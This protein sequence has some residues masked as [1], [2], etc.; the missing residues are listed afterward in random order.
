MTGASDSFWLPRAGSTLARE[1]DASFNLVYWVAVFFFLLVVGALV[2]FVVRY[3]RKVGAEVPRAPDHNTPIEIVWTA[4]PV[5]IVLVLFAVGFRVYLKSSVAP[6]DAM[7]VSVT[8]ERWMWTFTYPNGTVSVNELRVPRARPVKLILSSRDV[9]HSFFV[10]EM[11][12][13]KDAVPN[14]YTTLWFEA[15]EAGES[16]IQCTEYCGA[17]HS[18]MLG[19]LIVQED[20]DFDNWLESGGGDNKLP[21]AELG[22]RL[23]AKMACNTC[24][25]TDGLPKTGPTFKGIYGT[26]VELADG[27]SALVDE[28]YIRES[29]TSPAAKVVRGFQPVMPVFKGLLTQKQIDGLVAFIKEQK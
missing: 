27:T 8:A 11:R 24:H 29:I 20:K 14:S 23:F 16:T 18:S 7:E 4:I 19:K 25:T 15:T 6:A 12:V 21:P 2:V 1:V 28:N 5:A 10:P 22:A 26:R 17:G 3:R 9:I 13:K